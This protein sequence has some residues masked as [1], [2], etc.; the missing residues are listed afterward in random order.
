MVS[1]IPM[2]LHS[3][4][5][6]NWLGCCCCL[7]MTDKKKGGIYTHAVKPLTPQT[8]R[9]DILFYCSAVHCNLFN[10]IMNSPSLR[11]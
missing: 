7:A 1:G 5:I 8:A 11:D 6:A 4:F 2:A 9:S 3:F 10:E